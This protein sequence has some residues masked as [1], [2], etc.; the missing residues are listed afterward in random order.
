MPSAAGEFEIFSE[1]S[2]CGSDYL[3]HGKVY[4]VS[5]DPDIWMTRCKTCD[6]LSTPQ[7]PASE[8]LV[9][10]YDPDHYQA[11][12]SSSQLLS[13]KLAKFIVR[14]FEYKSQNTIR[15][16]DYGG[17]NGSLASEL[18]DNLKVLAPHATVEC[19]VVDVFNSLKD[20]SINFVHA[21][22]F[23]SIEGSFSFVIASAILEHLKRPGHDLQYLLNMV[24]PSG[25]F[26][27]RTPYEAPLVQLNIGYQTSW[28][29][30]LHDL[31]PKFWAYVIEK[32]GAE[33]EC[34][35]SETSI[36]ETAMSVNWIKAVTVSMLKFVS[37][38]ENVSV[39][40]AFKYRGVLWPFIG[41]WQV[42]LRRR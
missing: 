8:S 16:L 38:I 20:H 25:L 37:L 26:Y 3:E 14:N 5:R 18:R 31:G 42:V 13:K 30:H 6:A 29:V 4:A 21:D 15:I 24:E 36:N 27:A 32:N 9:D 7:I 41:G 11:A 22:N 28:P 39:R 12:L 35:K 1:C 34:L 40:K 10:L 23:S 17:G 19:I 33:F 2:F